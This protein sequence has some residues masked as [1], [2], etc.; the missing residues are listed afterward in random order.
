M[1]ELEVGYSRSEHPLRGPTSLWL[2][3]IKLGREFKRKQF[4]DYAD[5]AM[6]FYVG[7]D[8]GGQ[9]WDKYISGRHGNVSRDSDGAP[10]VDFHF[11]LAKV[12][13]LV[14]IFGPGLYH[15][16]PVRTV[17]CRR[18]PQIPPEVFGNPQD[19]RVQQM[20]GQLNQQQTQTYSLAKSR[21]T[22]MQTYL[23]Y[24]PNEYDLKKQARRAIN[25]ALIK[26]AGLLWTETFQHHAQGH[27]IIG[28]FYDSVDNLTID[29]DAETMEECW[30]IA[31]KVTEPVW[32]VSRDYGIDEE[33][34]RKHGNTKSAGE[35]ASQQTYDDLNERKPTTH[36]NDLLTYH[37]V[38]SKMGLGD[39]LG[40]VADEDRDTLGDFGQNVYLAVCNGIDFPLNLPSELFQEAL[41][42]PDGEAFDEAFGRVQWPIPFW[43]DNKWPFSALVFHEIPNNPW[44][45]SHIRPGLPE[46]KFNCWST[47]FL[48]TNAHHTSR[49]FAEVPKGAEDDVKEILQSGGGFNIIETMSVDGKP[50]F[51]FATP[52]KGTTVDL[53]NI[54]SKIEEAFEKRTGLN[55]AMYAAPGGM[56]SAEEARL[57]GQTMNIRPDDMAN[58]VEDWLSEVARKEGLATSWML[59]PP[60]L[61]PVLGP[62]GATLWE[63][64][65]TPMDPG[66]AAMEFDYRI[67]AGSARKPNKDAMIANMQSVMQAVMPILGPHA[68][69][70]GDIGSINSFIEGW[71]RANDIQEWEKYMLKPPPPP[72]PN[73]VEQQK[74]QLEQQKLQADIQK[75]HLDLQGKQM[76]L[77]GKQAEFQMK[78][79]DAQGKQ[80]S[81]QQNLMYDVASHQQELRQDE[82]VHDQELQQMADMGALKL[83]L[84][85]MMAR[86][87][88]TQSRNN[89]VENEPTTYG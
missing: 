49:L 44:P 40:S 76:D 48:A 32:K 5:E 34:L 66:Q 2:N 54:N 87:K 1:P 53:Q 70:T 62:G 74:M 10:E 16:N 9:L 25:E 50:L 38:Y 31:R 14:Q 81:Q 22:L 75:G 86:A 15:R 73:P 19:P 65:I 41:D 18:L 68:Q 42:D 78:Q 27:T 67:E 46:L 89:V 61:A 28:S 26:G 24:T 4:D 51:Q 82:E 47:S 43:I 8:S 13:E 52:P 7:D 63:Q 58:R 3:K 56:R 45:M 79:V 84:D 69:R 33:Y 39:L 29:P 20:V 60:D 35:M 11:V 17:T 37:K 23:N 64:L 12:A 59:E 6:A 36:T 55:E 85:R 83:S 72:Q 77:Q 88:T 80:V 30:W 71:C 21:A 57:K